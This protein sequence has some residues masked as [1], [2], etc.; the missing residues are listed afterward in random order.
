MDQLTPNSSAHPKQTRS[1]AL[2]QEGQWQS[3][4]E[5]RALAQVAEKVGSGQMGHFCSA[6]TPPFPGLPGHW[7]A[8]KAPEENT[9]LL[10]NSWDNFYWAWGRGWACAPLCLLQDPTWERKVILHPASLRSELTGDLWN[11]SPHWFTSSPS[12]LLVVFPQHLAQWLSVAGH[13]VNEEL[14]KSGTVQV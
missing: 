5:N 6:G 12:R 11:L 3:W 8:S 13:W 4:E 2:A 10:W 1:M 14:M 9:V 7:P